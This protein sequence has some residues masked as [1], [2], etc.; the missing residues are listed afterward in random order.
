MWGNK[1]VSALNLVVEVFNHLM[2]ELVFLD[3]HFELLFQLRFVL[4]AFKFWM[5]LKIVNQ[6]TLRQENW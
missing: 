5:L 6:R 2:E 4:L 3:N 1:A